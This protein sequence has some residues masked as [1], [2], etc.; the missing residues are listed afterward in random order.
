ME[1]MLK[2]FAGSDLDLQSTRA[3]ETMA[4]AAS[5]A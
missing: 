4:R 2:T 3:L 1:A 5:E